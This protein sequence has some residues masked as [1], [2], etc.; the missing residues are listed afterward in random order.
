MSKFIYAAV[1]VLIISSSPFAQDKATDAEIVDSLFMRV[2][3]GMVMF[4]D[5]V[6][7]S[8]LAIIGLGERAIPRMLTKLDTRSARE[9]HAVVDIFKG[10]GE[11]AVPALVK[12]LRSRD[13]YVR[14]LTIRCLGDIKS[15]LAIDSL[16]SYA[17]HEDY[18]TRSGVMDA[19]GRIGETRGANTVMAG[20]HDL[21]ELVATSAAVACGRIVE[22]IDPMALI[23]SL[24]HPYYGVRYSSMNSLVKLGET[25][26]EPLI[27]HVE[28]HE[29]D[30]SIGYAIEALGK[31]SSKKAVK[32]LKQTMKSNRWNIRAY[33]AQALGEINQGK[34]KKILKNALKEENHP[35]VISKINESLAMNDD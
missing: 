24:G 32:V 28:N 27:F 35:L 11:T 3:S 2:T 15:P 18:R 19:L 29:R 9:T 14:R 16:M 10:I 20:L 12:K 23:E 17:K 7:P 31:I 26:V 22:G 30:I 21:D 13:D 4:K 33:T 25:A 34:A 5:Q 8:R 6:E 1:L